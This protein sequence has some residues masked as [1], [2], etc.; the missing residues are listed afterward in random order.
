MQKA[1]YI[2]LNEMENTQCNL[3]CKGCY[4]TQGELKQGNLTEK[5][6]LSLIAPGTVLTRAYY[7]NSLDRD[8]NTKLD[9][10]PLNLAMEELA[11]AIFSENILVTDSLTAKRLDKSKL[12]RKGFNQVTFSPRS[13]SSA[14]ETLEHFKDWNNG[15]RLSVIFTVGL[16]NPQILKE[17]IKNGIRKIELNIA[18]PYSTQVFLEY[19]GYKSL[20]GMIAIERDITLLEDSCLDFVSEG[21]NCTNPDNQEWEITIIE[22][23]SYGYSCSYTTNNCIAK[24]EMNGDS[25]K[26]DT[27]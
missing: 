14:L 20:I 9:K 4:L 3:A 7:L 13:M 24:E 18:K 25:K 6:I 27:K 22:N 10:T 8:P 5:D 2:H 15:V 12:I 17:L 21:K 26:D 23:G 11:D 1:K 19:Q 16:D